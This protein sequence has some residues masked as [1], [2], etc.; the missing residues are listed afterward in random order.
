MSAPE[1]VLSTRRSP[2][3]R[4]EYHAALIVLSIVVIDF[5]FPAAAFGRIGYFINLMWSVCVL[6]S[7]RLAYPFTN[8]LTPV[9][10]YS[11]WF[12]LFV[13]RHDSIL[14]SDITALSLGVRMAA[15]GLIVSALL[16]THQTRKPCPGAPGESDELERLGVVESRASD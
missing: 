4:S 3:A 1:K 10:L 16:S 11:A 9:L 15:V 12:I 2:G 13:G 5:W 7:L 8:G 6:M 14:F